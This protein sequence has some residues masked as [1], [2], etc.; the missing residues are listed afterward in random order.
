MSIVLSPDEVHVWY[1][2]LDDPPWT[3]VQQSCVSL[4]SADEHARYDRFMFDK[5]RRQYLLARALVRTVL[6]CYAPPAP[7]DWEFATTPTGKP[8]V[9]AH[10]GL[11]HLQFN[12]SHA[13]SLV[14]CAVTQAHA[15][16]VDVES[17]DRHVHLGI[18]RHCLSESEL[19]QFEHA[20][21]QDR[22]AF[23]L[24]QWTLKEAY[25]KA[26]GLGLSLQF[27]DVSFAADAQGRPVLA[28]HAAM[29]DPQHW[30]FRQWLIEGRH[31]L[32]VAV[33]R[34]AIEPCRF[35]VRRSLPLPPK[36]TDQPQL[37]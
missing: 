14:A 20:D 15:V 10:F 21:P 37:C 29:D 19:Q 7:R 2:L 12:H 5:D 31:Y 11:S 1:S 22:Q 4:L 6:S 27:V 35:V 25:S 3:D 32:A 8:Y 30:Q 17:L 23:L 9:A 36:F 34:P 13:D 26:L 28:D 24:R 16:G 18:A 33:Q